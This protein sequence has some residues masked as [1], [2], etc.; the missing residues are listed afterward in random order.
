MYTQNLVIE[1]QDSEP[2]KKTREKAT[3]EQPIWMSESTVERAT[4]ATSNSVGKFEA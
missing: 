1:V 3:K 2:K 4:T